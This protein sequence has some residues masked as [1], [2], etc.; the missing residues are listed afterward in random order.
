VTRP[1]LFTTYKP[2]LEDLLGRWRT[3]TL[4]FVGGAGVPSGDDD[5]AKAG[6]TLWPGSRPLRELLQSA[7]LQSAAGSPKVKE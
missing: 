4:S 1:S 2:Q 7:I 5:L 3:R 6:A